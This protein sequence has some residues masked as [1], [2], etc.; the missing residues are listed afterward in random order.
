MPIC[1]LTYAV[2]RNI[3]AVWII[4]V[5]FNW[6]EGVQSTRLWHRRLDFCQATEALWLQLGKD[7]DFGKIHVV[8]ALCLVFQ[9]TVNFSVLSQD[10]NISHQVFLVVFKPNQTLAAVVTVMNNFF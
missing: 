3:I 5:F 7:Y 2:M 10:H 1:F 6:M 8:C 4:T 9:D